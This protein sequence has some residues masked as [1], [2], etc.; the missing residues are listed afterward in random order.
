MAGEVFV[1]FAGQDREFGRALADALNDLGVSVWF[2]ERR[3]RPGHGLRRQIEVALASCDRAAVILSPAFFGSEWP[4]RE[5]DGLFER[6][7]AEGR[8]IIVPIWHGILF[9]DVVRH[10]PMLADRFALDTSQGELSIARSLASLI[11]LTAVLSAEVR[12]A[13]A[14]SNLESPFRGA[15]SVVGLAGEPACPRCGTPAAFSGSPRWT[16]E[17]CALGVVSL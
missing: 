2:D 4:L 7:V 15:Q 17:V 13:V 6:E 3:L 9:E 5:L 12:T 16:C 14:D 1:C 11:D 10:S 8:E